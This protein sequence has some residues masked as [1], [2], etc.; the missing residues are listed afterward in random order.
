MEKENKKYWL[1]QLDRLG[2]VFVG[3]LL[4]GIIESIGIPKLSIIIS[5]ILI[6]MLLVVVWIIEKP[7]EV[8][9]K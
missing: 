3:I 2:L 4:G 9:N 6:F 8:Q 1:E 5:T 7:K